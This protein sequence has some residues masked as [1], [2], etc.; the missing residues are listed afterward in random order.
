M[1]EGSLKT[2]IEL[3]RNGQKQRAQQILQSLLKAD[4]HNIPAWF[5]YIETCTTAE[6]R[7][8][9]LKTCAR[10]NPNH[11]QVAQALEALQKQSN[12]TA[13]P[14]GKLPHTREKQAAQPSTADKDR[15]NKD[16]ESRRSAKP[17]RSPMAVIVWGITGG[18]LVGMVFLAISVFNSAPQ[19]PDA[20]R[21]TQP[22]EYYLYVPKSYNPEKAWPLFIGIHGSGGTGRDCWNLWQTHAA[23]EKF[24]L[25]CPSLSGAG[26]GWYQDDGES[27]TWAAINQVTGNYNI[28]PRFFL[29]GF[30]AGAQFVQGFSFNHPYS[31]RAAAILSAGNY[32][33]PSPAS[34]GIPFL[35]VIGDRDNA[36]S[37][38]NSQ[39]FGQALADNGSNVEYWLLPGVGHQ[40]T[41][42]TIQLTIK[43][44]NSVFNQ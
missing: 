6:Q 35:I 24:I 44:F 11:A 34:G 15:R 8:Q 19:T 31:V 40:V 17:G 27:K 41:N 2:A 29:V 18:L 14:H 9:A 25:L 37:I 36:M 3:I 28:E 4:I 10:Y 7:L 1:N 32:Y 5:W 30:S 23:R 33:A 22:V 43:F 26:G 42:K 38:K 20:H 13:V 39:V 21:H 12:Q 16:Q